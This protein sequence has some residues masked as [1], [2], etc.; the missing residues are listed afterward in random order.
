MKVLEINPTDGVETPAL[1]K[2]LPKYLSLNEGVELLKNVQ[3]DFY[4]RDYC[5]LTL[6]LN[7]GMRLSELLISILPI[8]MMTARSG[9]SGKAIKSGSFI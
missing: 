6:F 5:I 4:E 7:C 8:F 1:K 3:S 2:R 9:S